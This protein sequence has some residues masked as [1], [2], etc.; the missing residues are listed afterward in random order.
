MSPQHLVMLVFF[1]QP[2]AFGAW[3]PR[4][5]GI[6][7]APG[8]GSAELALALL[9]MPVGI[10]LTLPFAGRFVG[11][12]GARTTSLYGFMVFAAVGWASHAVMEPCRVFSLPGTCRDRASHA[13]SRPQRHGRLG[14]KGDGAR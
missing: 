6:Q 2:I 5:P 7:R 9:G 10:L 8:L 1:L 14:R 4:I 3:L 11:H 13:G 12:I